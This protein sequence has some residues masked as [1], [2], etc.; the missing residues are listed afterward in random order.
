MRHLAQP[1]R[2]FVVTVGVSVWGYLQQKDKRDQ[3]QREGH[4]LRHSAPASIRSARHLPLYYRPCVFRA[5][6]P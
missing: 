4:W 3:C 5:Y 2:C 1:A 6:V